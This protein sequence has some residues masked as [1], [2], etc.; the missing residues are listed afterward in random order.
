MAPPPHAPRA[1]PPPPLHRVG[2]AL[3]V[4]ALTGAACAYV[5]LVDPH[6]PGH[7]PPCPVRALTGLHCPGCGGL[8]S[9]HALTHGSPLVAL[10]ANA[11]VVLG[12]AALLAAYLTHAVRGAPSRWPR[13]PRRATL[14]R[15]TGLI[16]TVFTVL[17]NL[18]LGAALAP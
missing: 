10:R 18:P 16:I 9:V 4:L 1:S 14:L 12:G 3:T 15:A 5:A 8:R 6:V 11:L 17:R 7:Y 2:A 13:A